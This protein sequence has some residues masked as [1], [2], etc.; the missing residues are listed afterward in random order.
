MKDTP[1]PIKDVIKDVISRIRDQ[2]EGGRLTQE[3]I[4]GVWED[5]V[6]KRYARYSKPISLRKGKL[7][8]NVRDSSLL[9]ELTSK[10]AEFLERLSGRTGDKKIERIHFRIGEV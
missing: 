8:V 6:G 9:F 7:V 1:L 4:K 2:K 5:I 10:T 3:Y